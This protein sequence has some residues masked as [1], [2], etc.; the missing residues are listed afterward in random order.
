M[1]T[2]DSTPTVPN[3]HA[4]YPAFAGIGGLLA[5]LTMIAGRREVAGF[6]ARLTR[7]ARGDRVVDVGC[8][9]GGAAREAARLGATV[10][11]IDPAAPMLGLARRLT[12]R[13]SA[14]EW[15]EG[16]AEHLPIPDDSASV[17]W[18]ISSVHHWRDVDA[19]VA[20][21]ARVLAPRGRFLAIEKRARPGASGHASHGW[22]DEQAELFARRCRAAGF[23]DVQ[24]ETAKL[25]KRTVLA[26]HGSAP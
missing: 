24:V 13:R 12:R 3:H 15:I 26:V 18:S 11:G 10:T 21:A 17:L 19:G 5:G 20:E 23:L 16:T 22:T 14:I 6:A 25:E 4:D 2:N 8:G 7:I 1:Q 9:P